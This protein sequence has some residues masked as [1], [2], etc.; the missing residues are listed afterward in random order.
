MEP[1]IQNATPKTCSNVSL[2]GTGHPP[3]TPH[4]RMPTLSSMLAAAVNTPEKPGLPFNQ[5]HHTQCDD[6]PL[7]YTLTYT[8]RRMIKLD[9]ANV[10]A[11]VAQSRIRALS[12]V[13]VVKRLPC[14]QCKSSSQAATL[15]YI[16]CW[17]F[18]P[19]QYGDY[20][21]KDYNPD[22]DCTSHATSSR[23]QRMQRMR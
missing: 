22:R 8:R 7:A 5:S 19:I 18:E 23:L 3:D 6:F 15:I 21:T 12:R 11:T 1:R 13:I 16:S 10:T 17:P 4:L 20:V 14:G 9:P 2:T